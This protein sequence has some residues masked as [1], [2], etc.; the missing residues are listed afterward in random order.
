MVQTTVR[1]VLSQLTPHVFVIAVG[2]S[3]GVFLLSLAP[4][5]ETLVAK[6]WN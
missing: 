3:N 2:Q 5:V 1:Q 6:V 4:P